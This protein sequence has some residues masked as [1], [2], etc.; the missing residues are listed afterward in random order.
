[1]ALYGVE[2]FVA[3]PS[4]RVKTASAPTRSRRGKYGRSVLADRMSPAG[5]YRI[6]ST[7]AEMCE[8]T[9]KEKRTVERMS[10]VILLH[11]GNLNLEARALSATDISIY[12]VG[13]EEAKATS[14]DRLA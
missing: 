4:F 13:K 9:G 6:G 2:S 7:L 12:C 8:V 11:I 14:A 5:L 10:D 3:N 1:M